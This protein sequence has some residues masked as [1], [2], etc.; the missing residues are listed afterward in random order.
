[1]ARL[2]Y[3]GFGELSDLQTGTRFRQAAAAHYMAREQSVWYAAE[4]AADAAPPS[5]AGFRAQLQ[6]TGVPLPSEVASCLSQWAPR[7]AFS[8]GQG[9][10]PLPLPDGQVDA[11]LQQ[12]DQTTICSDWRMRR[13]SC[14]PWP[15]LRARLV[16]P[17]QTRHQLL[18]W[19]PRLLTRPSKP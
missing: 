11:V 15:G 3:L 19:P 9:H 1:M 4:L 13:R 6:Q 12:Y 16:K 17:L 14:T 8:P 5:L 2:V 7:D 18:R 10:P